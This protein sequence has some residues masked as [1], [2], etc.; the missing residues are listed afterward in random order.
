MNKNTVLFLMC[1]LTCG[2]GMSPP[3]L[4]HRKTRNPLQGQIPADVN[5]YT[6]SASQ[7]SRRQRRNRNILRRILKAALQSRNQRPIYNKCDLVC[8]RQLSAVPSALS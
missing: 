8:Q 1:R 2:E 5:A 4:S 6:V 3:L 7:L